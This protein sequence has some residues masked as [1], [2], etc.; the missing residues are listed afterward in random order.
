MAST[1]AG[2]NPSRCRCPALA[3]PAVFL[4]VALGLAAP[5][6]AAGQ[7]AG[8]SPGGAAQPLTAAQAGSGEG[9][10][11]DDSP[12]HMVREGRGMRPL[13]I[14]PGRVAEFNQPGTDHPSLR[15]PN[16]GEREGGT[17]LGKR[18][19]QSA[20][21]A[22][23]SPV[24]LDASGMPW[25]L[26]G[27]VIVAL[28]QALGEPQAR[29]QLQ[30]AGLSPLRRIGDRMWLVES[31]A[32]MASLDLAERLHSEGQFEFVQPNWWHRRTKK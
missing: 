9:S 14:D 24:F 2:S 15:A 4:L 3:A 25:A 20:G 17:R 26:P 27:G 23:V 1:T 18:D 21:T 28:K 19:A 16:S 7:A 30:A 5:A 22:P 13:W 6:P 8:A 11:S 10:G 29:A 31:P 32:G 12:T